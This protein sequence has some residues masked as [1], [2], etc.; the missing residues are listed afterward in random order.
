VPRL[1]SWALA[2]CRTVPSV[3]AFSPVQSA[4]IG[5]L[6]LPTSATAIR[7]SQEENRAPN[8]AL[9]DALTAIAAARGL[10]PAQLALAWVLAQKPCSVPI[11]GTRRIEQLQENIAAAEVELSAADLRQIED[12]WAHADVAGGRNTQATMADLDLTEH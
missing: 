6:T 10:T 3:V 7:V 11:P 9:V 2:S 12:T 4:A 1:K 8:I 5:S